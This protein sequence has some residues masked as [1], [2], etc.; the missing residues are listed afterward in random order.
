[1]ADWMRKIIR[2]GIDARIQG[3]VGEWLERVRGA[4]NSVEFAASPAEDLKEAASLGASDDLLSLIG[5]Y[6]DPSA[7]PPRGHYDG[8]EKPCDDNR[9]IAWGAARHHLLVDT[10]KDG[11]GPLPLGAPGGGPN[12][13]MATIPMDRRLG[14][15]PEWVRRNIRDR[16]PVSS[17]IYTYALDA[18]DP[19]R[20]I[21]ELGSPAYGQIYRYAIILNNKTMYGL[22]RGRI[23]RLG[24][25]CAHD[26][27]E[28]VESLL[29]ALY[30]VHVRD[31]DDILP[32]TADVLRELQELPEGFMLETMRGE[33]GIPDRREYAES[34]ERLGDD[35]G[36][37]MIEAMRGIQLSG[38]LSM[39]P[40]RKRNSV[41][42]LAE[43]LAADQGM[44]DT[45]LIP[46]KTSLETFLQC[47]GEQ[48]DHAI[49][50]INRILDHG[51][52]G[53]LRWSVL[54]ET[55]RATIGGFQRIPCPKWYAGY[56]DD[57]IMPKTPAGMIDGRG[58][59]GE[60][61]VMMRAILKSMP[62]TMGRFTATTGEHGSYSGCVDVR[63]MVMTAMDRFHG[64][65]RRQIRTH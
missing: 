55:C 48:T 43:R 25:E 28:L 16:I 37:D 32:V 57:G 47:R 49:S 53:I 19:V 27:P 5:G 35:M 56:V 9:M 63:D 34:L 18:C 1:M 59:G 11:G 61:G 39:V 15:G 30:R 20:A 51:R 42:E 24:A 54:A 10:L 2:H 46:D 41:M 8:P 31:W 38:I 6:H 13:Q 23:I 14:E 17:I 40:A 62:T 45:P 4:E 22:G 21:R 52:D 33:G 36:V 58:D 65:D 60:A 50:R 64:I 29:E 3:P 44:L 26:G 7:W 12:G